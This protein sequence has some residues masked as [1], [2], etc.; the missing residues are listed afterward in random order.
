MAVAGVY[1]P[2]V[3][4][5]EV[6]VPLLRSLRI[7]DLTGLGRAGEE[8]RERLATGL[9]RLDTRARLFVER[10]AQALAARAGRADGPV[11]AGATLTGEA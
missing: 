1:D 9:D 11:P 4:H 2:K 10:R 6:L 8:A 7:L 5:D 3:H